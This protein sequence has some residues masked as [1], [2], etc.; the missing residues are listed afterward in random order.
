MVNQQLLDYIKQQLQQGID[1]NQIKQVLLNNGWQNN[2]I[3]EA[4]NII[5]S[6][7]VLLKKRKWKKIIFITVS[8]LL[9]FGL[10]LFLLPE[11][12][13]LF[14]KD[15]TPID[16]SDLQLQKVFVSDKDNA[17]FDL[18]KI[19]DVIYMPKDK[20]PTILDMVAGKTWDN[21][22]AEEI[23]SKNSEAF[24]YFSEAV[25]KPKYQNPTYADP[26]KIFNNYISSPSTILSVLDQMSR[27]SAIQALYLAKQNKDEEALNEALNSVNIGQKIQDSQD[28][29]LE[30]ITGTKMKERGLE[31]MQKI[32]SSSNLKSSELKKYAQELDKF[33]NNETGLITAFKI[34]YY[35]QSFT[36]DSI[37][38]GVMKM[39][40]SLFEDKE[41]Q[42]YEIIKKIENN[43]YF[44]PNKTK[45]LFAEDA[46]ANIK[47]VNQ[48]CGEININTSKKLT[49][50]NPIR[51]YI[52]ENVVG[53]MLYDVLT[54]SLA[55][56]IRKKCQEDLLVGATQ[57]IIAIKA[58]KNDTGNYPNSLNELIPN[59]LSSIPK[60]PF[61]KKPLKYSLTKKIIYS[62][63]EDVEDSG[64][65]T[66]ND[67]RKMADPTFQINF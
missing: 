20:L 4:F 32:I 43:Y 51:L 28:Y 60:D 31:T 15:I 56:I 9:I 17:Y 63:G 54:T 45:L 2:D 59:Y 42:Y 44:Q 49:P 12:L 11:F 50:T 66:G 46:R 34:E 26:E 24:K 33:Y 10:F 37:V 27:L 6:K 55:D 18:I 3:E 29:L 36:V 62:V 58:Y 1:A 53:K 13:N 40:K 30:Y 22:F 25:L 65:S 57:A 35:I 21:Q 48:S 23:I 67:W 52:E 39:L 41:N 14:A 61:D 47:N 7:P 8:I 16:D 38:R 5:M 19:K 64:G